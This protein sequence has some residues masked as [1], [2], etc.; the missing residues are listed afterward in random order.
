MGAK[1]THPSFS[2]DGRSIVALRGSGSHRR[3]GDLADE[4]WSDVVLLDAKTGA[5]RVVTET[6][7]FV[8][9]VRPRFSADGRRLLFH[10]SEAGEP[11]A[12]ENGTLVSVNLDGT[13]RRKVLDVG[14]STEINP[15]PDGSWIAFQ[16]EHHAWLAA[17]PTVGT[18]LPVLKSGGGVPVW[19]LSPTAGGWI[20]FSADGRTVAWIHGRELRTLR[21]DALLDWDEEQ[22]EEARAKA[23]AGPDPEG[24]AKETAP[25]PAA[26]LPPS[27]AYT[28]DLRQPRAAPTGVVAFTGARVI[29]MAGDE[30]LEGATVVVKDDRIAAVG[31]GV[32]IPEGAHVVDAAGATIMPGIV[33]V[34]AHLHFSSWGTLPQQPWRYLANLAYGV[35]TV[36][37]PSAFSETAFGQAEL[38][39]TGDMIG[40]RVFSTGTILYGAAGNF[41]SD[42]QSREDADRH[43][44]RMKDLGAISVK[45]YQQPRRD[46]RQWIV[47][48]CREQGLL[49]VPEGGGDLWNNL[50]MIIDGHSAI[51]HSI[52]IAPLYDDVIKLMSA[53][54]TFYSP[55]LLVSYG[56]PFGELYYYA[57]DRVWEN[58]RLLTYTPRGVIDRRA[59]RPGGLWP[60]SEWFFKDVARAAARLQAAGTRVTLGAHGQMQG[61]GAHW[62][63]WSLATEGAMT[64]HQALRA[65][66]LDGALYLGMG[67]HLGSVEAGKLADFVILDANPLDDIENS[68]DVR[69]VVKNG[70]LYDAASMNRMYPNPAV[71]RPLIWEAAER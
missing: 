3:G 50:S 35:T 31:V 39:E 70:V 51:E 49:D 46:Q 32:P 44:R 67:D 7:G 68:D 43:V 22:R 45:S 26:D 8:E 10:E 27:R 2:P 55:T 61:L 23:E 59:R 71:R 34:H 53:S 57:R 11:Y 41:R 13:D 14:R 17:W 40:P 21:I 5:T 4:L 37:D 9:A 56:G 60:D 42:I 36:H 18:S 69:W 54:S 38:V 24:D 58:E 62:E 16:E 52:P 63:L 19:K 15:S 33:D 65:A 30:V 66:T 47:E 48:A 25:D 12:A 6:A 20:D 1:Y 28:L 64:P 29:T